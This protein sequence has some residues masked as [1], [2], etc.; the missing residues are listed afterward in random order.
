L[1]QLVNGSCAD[2]FSI[3]PEVYDK[4]VE[5]PPTQITEVY[6]QCTLT[7][8]DAVNNAIG[9]A[10]GNT[11]TIVPVVVMLL[12]PFIY[13]WLKA[14]NIPMPVPEYSEEQKKDVVEF[15]ITQLMRANDKKTRGMKKNGVLLRLVKELR[16]ADMYGSRYACDSDDSDE[17][18]SDD[19]APGD[20]RKDGAPGAK[21][22]ISRRR[23]S[24]FLQT[25][26]RQILAEESNPIHKIKRALSSMAPLTDEDAFSAACLKQELKV[27]CCS[28]EILDVSLDDFIATF[29]EDSS[30]YSLAV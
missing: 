5:S 16:H 22:T 11:T 7:E 10:S 12:L 6:Y 1:Y 15:F 17:D 30:L 18:F 19:D 2:P 28:N 29:L 27:A 25:E 4:L 13:L 14:F 9:I 20:E 21:R 3:P 8:L 23:S 26:T 24:G